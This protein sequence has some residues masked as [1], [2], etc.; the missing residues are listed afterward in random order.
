LIEA[1]KATDPLSTILFL[2]IHVRLK[3]SHLMRNS[4]RYPLCGRGDI[5][6][7]TVFAE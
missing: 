1:L 7:Y 2:K 4:G 5:N 3:G 6:V